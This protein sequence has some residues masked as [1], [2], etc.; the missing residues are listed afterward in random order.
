MSKRNAKLGTP[1]AQ[2][3]GFHIY[4]KDKNEK[5]KQETGKDKVLTKGTEIS[6]YKGRNKVE[7]GFKNKATALARVTELLA[8]KK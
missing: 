8:E 4:Q 7:G 2:V 1:I 5:V 6:I 3:Q